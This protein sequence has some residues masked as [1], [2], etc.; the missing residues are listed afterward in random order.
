MVLI[1][2]MKLS[3]GIKFNTTTLVFDGFV[4]IGIYTPEKQKGELGDHALVLMF[5][6]FQSSWVQPLACFL[7]KSCANSVTL[8][9]LI[10]ECLGLL[11]KS[12]FYCDGIV[13]DAA[14]WNRSV[15]NRF[16]ISLSNISAEHSCDQNR[17]LWFFS[18]F[19]HLMKTFRNKLMS[20][21]YFHVSTQIR[22]QCSLR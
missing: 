10:I 9:Y 21:D 12:G 15:W 8:E 13:T 4:D 22:L 17:R 19:P 7:T 20:K 2:E 1:D 14:A 3:E 16:G 6:P 11:E 18:D 5:Q